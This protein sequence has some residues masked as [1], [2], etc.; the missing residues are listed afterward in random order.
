VRRAL[1]AAALLALA[2]AAPASATTA[3]DVLTT[4]TPGASAG[5][6]VKID[7]ESRDANGQSRALRKHTFTFPAGTVFDPAGAGVCQASA[8]ELES[9]GPSACPADSRVGGG[10]LRAVVTK[11][12]GSLGG[13]LDA[14]LTIFNASHPKDA[15]AVEHGLIVAVSIGGHVQTAFVAP[16][17]GN[18]ATEEPPVICASPA[19]Q[20]PCPNGEITVKSVDYRIEERSRSANG[21]Q[22]RLIT[23]PPRCPASGRWDFGHLMEYRDGATAAAS[24]SNPCIAS[25]V[26]RIRLAVTPRAVRRCRVARFVFSAVTSDGPVAGATVRFANRRTLTDNQGRAAIPARICAPG[27]RRATVKADGFKTGVTRVRVVR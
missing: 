18:V 21:E 13:P 26:Q 20:P 9:D 23:T 16:L 12:P 6:H 27:L 17:R 19:E 15:P 7:Y 2:G 4:T 8:A 5:I 24:S 1:A 10:I 11:P 25:P 22:H 3:E 14:E